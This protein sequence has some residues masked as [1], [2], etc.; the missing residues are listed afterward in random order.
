LSV[1]VLSQ[2]TIRFLRIFAFN[3]LIV[4]FFESHFILLVA[5]ALSFT[6]E[7]VSQQFT[8]NYYF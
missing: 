6:V 4:G 3:T 8:S 2:T 1:I 7:Y 5:V